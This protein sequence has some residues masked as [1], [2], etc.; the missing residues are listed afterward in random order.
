[1]GLIPRNGLFQFVGEGARAEIDASQSVTAQFHRL[2]LLR[3]ES[4]V[5]TDLSRSTPTQY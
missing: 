4:W 5:K 3:T 1:M 2:L